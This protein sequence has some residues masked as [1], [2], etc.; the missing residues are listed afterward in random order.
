MPILEFYCKKCGDSVEM[1]TTRISEEEP[2][3]KCVNCNEIMS[4]AISGCMV[5]FGRRHGYTR[6]AYTN[7]NVVLSGDDGYRTMEQSR[8]AKGQVRS[9]ASVQTPRGESK[10][11]CDNE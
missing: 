8:W 4:R 1:I 11:E 2:E 3:V 7:K 5:R 6:N 10:F 9:S